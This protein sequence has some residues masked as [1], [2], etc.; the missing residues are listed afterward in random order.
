MYR[1]EIAHLRDRLGYFRTLNLKLKNR[2]KK[3]KKP[4][5]RQSVITEYFP[6]TDTPEPAQLEFSTIPSTFDNYYYESAPT[7]PESESDLTSALID[8]PTVE[9]DTEPLPCVASSS[10]GA[11][12]EDGCPN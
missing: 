10:L 12:I 1:R 6:I 3:L 4:A 7:L 8:L 5:T 9:I 11:C 2:I